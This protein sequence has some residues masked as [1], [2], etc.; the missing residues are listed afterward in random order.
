MLA[1]RLTFHTDVTD[2]PQSFD[3]AIIGG[4]L[5][6][7]TLA[8]QLRQSRPSLSILV[9]EKNTLPPPPAA[10]KVG[11][12]TVEIGAH[13]LAHTL[14]LKDH[15]EA[16]Q[17]RKFGLRL[18]FGSG[19]NKDLANAD[20]LGAS[21]L[22]PAISYQLDRGVLEKDLHRMLVD[23]GVDV[24]DCSRVTDVVI[25]TPPD[26]H[27]ITVTSDDAEYTVR[28]QWLVDASSRSA[29]LKRQLKLTEP[30]EHQMSAAWFRL[31][32]S[33]SV[34]EWSADK[35][36]QARCNGLSRM[37]STNHLMGCGYWAW[38]IPLVGGRSSIGLV[39]DPAIVSLS[40][41]DT[42]EK[43]RSWLGKHQPLLAE[44]V[45]D[46]A[47]ALMDFRKL[48]KLAHSSKRVWSRDRWAMT[49]EAGVFADPFYSPGTDFIALS[50][51]FITDLVTRR[52]GDTERGIRS[53]VYEKLYQSFFQSTMTLYQDQYGGF[54]DTR[55]MSIKLTWDYAYYWSILAWL[56]FRDV[57]TDL[58]FLRSAQPDILAIRALNDTMQGRFRA[59]AARRQVDRGTGR[60]IDQISI[61]LMVELNAALLEPAAAPEKELGENC[62]RLRRLAPMLL[63]MVDGRKAPGGASTLLGD[64]EARLA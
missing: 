8:L 40:S 30:S 16:T 42:F 60:F 27:Q 52:C 36:W 41:Y 5:A 10:H 46:R 50:N 59:C 22:L 38:I 58:T 23:R 6:G 13:Y 32:A 4:G 3:V 24:R 2:T 20:E 57:L 63:A 47:D 31:D 35:N 21:S 11:E 54:G 12:A 33:I 55:L 64:L 25:N 34:D 56:Y 7:L 18:F 43:F 51:T 39:S 62:E 53:S 48:G 14:G 45:D 28:C 29:V 61:P 17:L 49:G 1:S 44:R 26:R 9:V 37:P 19:S 15:L